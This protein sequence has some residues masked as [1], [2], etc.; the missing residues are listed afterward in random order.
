[1]TIQEALLLVRQKCTE[2]QMGATAGSVE[3]KYRQAC[4][5]YPATMNVAHHLFARELAKT[6]P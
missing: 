6:L 1:M 5:E 4:K 3:E 2:E